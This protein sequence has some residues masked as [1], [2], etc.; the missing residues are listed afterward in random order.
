MI[1]NPRRERP[2]TDLISLRHCASHM[3]GSIAR[4]ASGAFADA[5]LIARVVVN[6]DRHAFSELVR[7]H[8]SAVRASLRKLTR[9]D[10]GLADDL[11]QETFILAYRNLS[12]FRF[13]AKFPP[14][15]IASPTTYSSAMHAR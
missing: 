12:K 5:D 9:G 6:D 2:L 8:Q 14:G 1:P 3:A 11:A 10:E 13:D 7:R 4:P 15:C